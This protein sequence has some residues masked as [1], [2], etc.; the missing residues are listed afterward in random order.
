MVFNNFKNNL[1]KLVFKTQSV[2]M[3]KSFQI[4][5]STTTPTE[6]GTNI[7]PPN[8][9]GYEKKALILSEPSK[10]VVVNTN[11]V[12]YGEATRSWGNVTYTIVYDEKGTPLFADPIGASINV[13]PGDAVKIRVGD[14]KLYFGDAIIQA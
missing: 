11:E 10:G 9:P 8:D 2:I 6:D 4:G 7:T 14:A 5:F 3:P 12:D 13:Q 1:A